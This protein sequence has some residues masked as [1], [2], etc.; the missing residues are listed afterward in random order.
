M[1]DESVVDRSCWT[2]WRVQKAI[3]WRIRFCF[4]I[5]HF[6]R[7]ISTYK[8]STRLS[9]LCTC[10]RLAHE[11]FPLKLGFF[12]TTFQL[13]STLL[14]S[15]QNFSC[16]LLPILDHNSSVLERVFCDQLVSFLNPV[17]FSLPL[18]PFLSSARSRWVSSNVI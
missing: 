9:R 7:H 2:C 12:N 18:L 13:S 1:R 6:P 17:A 16:R 3:F 5:H 10:S 11:L 4:R 14:Q 8:S 15:H